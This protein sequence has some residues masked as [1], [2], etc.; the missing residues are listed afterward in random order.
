MAKSIGTL[1]HGYASYYHLNAVEHVIAAPLEI[2]ETSF[3]H[4]I[5]IIPL[6]PHPGCLAEY[7]KVRECLGTQ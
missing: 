1:S 6:E 7:A 4:K 5:V 3:G 2:Q